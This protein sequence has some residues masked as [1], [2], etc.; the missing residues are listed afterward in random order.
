MNF[1][2]RLD[3]ALKEID[4]FYGKHPHG[5]FIH[6]YPESFRKAERIIDERNFVEE[7]LYFKSSKLKSEKYY[8]KISQSKDFSIDK[9]YVDQGA[10]WNEPMGDRYFS[11]AY[12]PL[13]L[14]RIDSSLSKRIQEYKT[15]DTS[16]TMEQLKKM[17]LGNPHLHEFIKA[18]LYF[19]LVN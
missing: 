16:Y 19:N 11:C 15:G 5:T 17:I 10:R 1:L 6:H 9:F 8:K 4:E 13:G 18:N 14:Q 2:E 12:L 7:G 3:N